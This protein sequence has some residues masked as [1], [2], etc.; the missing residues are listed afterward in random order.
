MKK[1]IAYGCLASTIILLGKG[2]PNDVKANTEKKDNLHTV[3]VPVEQNKQINAKSKTAVTDQLIKEAES[4][5]RTLS[6]NMFVA[7]EIGM[8][9]LIHNTSPEAEPYDFEDT[10]VAVVNNDMTVKD[11]IALAANTS[12][13]ENTTG[14]VQ[15]MKTP[16]FRY[17]KTNTVKTASTHSTGAALTTTGKLSFPVVGGE[18]SMNVHYDYST[19]KEQETKEEVDWNV[20]SQ[21]L[22]VPAGKT[23]KVE[24]LLKT[25]IATGTTKLTSQVR[26]YIPYKYIPEENWR[27]TYGF[28]D[29]VSEYYS[30]YENKPKSWEAGKDYWHVY[31]SRDAV[32]RRWGT[33]RYEAEYGTEFIMK[34]SDVSKPNAPISVKTIPLANIAKPVQK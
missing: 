31:T 21:E 3:N 28:A 25:G 20:P 33:A 32:E 1:I 10:T 30:K 7:G 29:A 12:T 16:S 4:L 17:T 14:S 24:W 15:V 22:E 27:L 8:G 26:G 23:Y 9:N 11:G 18:I 34:V 6:Y 2:V 5:S 19:T 13:L